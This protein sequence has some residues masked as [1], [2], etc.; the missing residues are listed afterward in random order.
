[1]AFLTGLDRR[2]TLRQLR[3]VCAIADTGR[4]L[5]AADLLGVSQPALT[6]VLHE[7]EE[8]FGVALFERH[9]RGVTPTAY[10]EALRESA[11]RILD[12]IDGLQE[13]V[14]GMMLRQAGGLAIAALPSAAAGLLP[15]VIARLR[16]SH[17]DLEIRLVQGR[18]DEMLP[19]LLSG[20]VDLLV[21]RLYP[22]G[23]KL[24]VA[25]R[26][27]Y[28]EPLGLLARA[29][30]PLA[31]VAC[32]AE[33]L[34]GYRLVLPTFSQRMA[35]EVEPWLAVLGLEAG[36]GLRTSAPAVMRELVLAS[37]DILVLPPLMMAG[38]I[39]RGALVRLAAPAA[40]P[41]RPGG[42]MYRH[43]V[44][45]GDAAKAALRVVRSQ[46][47]ALAEEGIIGIR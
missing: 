46:I 33:M 8:M 23:A 37:D 36:L 15:G 43:G 34:R 5:A 35:A 13:R 1:M 6:R 32:S 12:E 47:S 2:L 30:H 7:L 42:V 39:S 31:G 29:G 41:A 21:G 14:N 38:D 19:V 4:L 40:A 17:P 28:D 27:L 20:G 22:T 9:P 3:A 10:G 24:G 16:V 25:S 45:L 18:L 26:V 11:E 44:K